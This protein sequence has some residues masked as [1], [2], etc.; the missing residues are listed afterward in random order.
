VRTA[1]KS[2][3]AC[4]C[5]VLLGGGTFSY[6]ADFDRVETSKAFIAGKY[7]EVLEQ[8][9]AALA[10]RERGEDVRLLHANSLWM[11]GQY[12][13]AR[14]A[15]QQAC[16]AY[17]YSVRMRLAAY[18]IYR[19]AG[20]VDAANEMLDEINQ[21]AGGRRIG[22]GNAA[23]VVALGE[24]AVLL[25]V[26]PRLVLDNFLSPARKSDPELRDGP[27]AVGRLALGKHDYALA[28]KAFQE[29]LQKFKDDPDFLVGLAEALEPDNRREML[30]ALEKAFEANPNHLRGRMLLVDH[31]VDAEE[32]KAAAEELDKIAKVNPNYPPMWAYRAVLARL[33]ND[34]EGEASA[35]SAGLRYWT[36]NPEVDH[37]IGLKLSQKYR[38]GEG[39]EFQR[40]ALKFQPDYLPAKIQLAQDLLRLGQEGEGWSLAHSVFEADAYDVSSY[41][42]VTLHD[43]MRKF[44]TLTNDHFYLRMSENEAEIYGARALELLEKARTELTRKYGLEL[45]E[46]VTVEIFP[47]QKDFAVRTFGMP[48]GEGYLGVCFGNV[49]TAN[50]PVSQSMHWPSVLWHEFCHVVTLNLTKNKMPRWLS[51]GISVYEERQADPR[52]GEQITPK[53][54]DFILEGEMKPIADL[55]AAFMAPK[56]ALHLQFAY[57]QC[58]LVVEYIVG[59]FGLESI[60]RILRDLGE[61][62]AINDALVAHTQPMPALE[63]EFEAF[64]KEKARALGPDT[65]WAKPKRDEQGEIDRTWANLHPDSFWVLS[66]RAAV[67]MEQQ[68]WAEAAP[69]LEKCIEAYPEQQG[70]DNAYRQLAVVYRQL[71]ELAKERAVLQRWAEIDPEAGAG[72]ARLIELDFQRSPE[73]SAEPLAPLS[74]SALQTFAERLIAVN[75]ALPQSYRALASAAEASAVPVKAISAYRTLLKLNPPDPAAIRYDLARLLH[76]TGDPDAK[77]QVLLALQDAPR[78]RDAHR[79]YLEIADKKET[80]P[81]VPPSPQEPPSPAPA[82]KSPAPTP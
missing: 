32:Y 1:R 56:S 25:G 24:A 14:E 42:L 38:F 53:Y 51:E 72:L 64:A 29:G 78:F 74:P 45:T 61:G 13:E 49:I 26:D 48:G 67:L 23:D 43:T 46:R 59:K 27:L 80:A 5:S 19:S 47:Q 12:P 79:L 8:T 30:R 57:Y 37:K 82:L 33:R 4:L 3:A 81:A 44:V 68:N 28:A 71:G 54:R 10:A 58:S 39:A 16:R 20:E 66:E 76:K 77:R 2:L 63:K 9:T 6:A 65:L 40:Q 21:L 22:L 17:Y 35:R 52:W 55:S 50:S 15:I 41:N 11:T 7:A 75:P 31:L 36:T 18:H 34:A 62:R 70:G 60:Q 73:G 69:L